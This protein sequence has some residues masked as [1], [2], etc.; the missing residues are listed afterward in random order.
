MNKFL[1]NI[2]IILNLKKSKD[3]NYF[4][5]YFIEKLDLRFPNFWYAHSNEQ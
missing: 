1:K 2:T 3:K 5:I 4:L